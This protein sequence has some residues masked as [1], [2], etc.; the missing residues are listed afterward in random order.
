MKIKRGERERERE[1]IMIKQN[2]GKRNVRSFTFNLF[3]TSSQEPNE[4]LGSKRTFSSNEL[5]YFRI[6][7][8]DIKY[9]KGGST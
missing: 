2:R 3:P 8:Q 7:N 9:E 5:R 6:S 1:S 4:A